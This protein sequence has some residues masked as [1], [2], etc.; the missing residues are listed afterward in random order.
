MK[1]QA[2]EREIDSAP[3]VIGGLNL[4]PDVCEVTLTPDVEAQVERLAVGSAAA[5]LAS[6]KRAR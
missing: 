1:C 5:A 6:S 3:V 4:C 2:C